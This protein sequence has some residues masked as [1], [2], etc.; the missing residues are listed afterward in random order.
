MKHKTAAVRP[1]DI[2]KM[3]GFGFCPLLNHLGISIFSYTLSLLQIYLSLIPVF[4]LAL[5]FISYLT[6]TTV[7]A[8]VGCYR[9]L[10]M[11]T[12]C[13]TFNILRQAWKYFKFFLILSSLIDYWI[14]LKNSN[15]FHRILTFPSAWSLVKSD[16][17]NENLVI[18]LTVLFLLFPPFWII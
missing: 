10:S 15:K 3:A 14:S 17:V 1:K 7:H 12:V 5:A 6:L 9:G 16:S 4:M 8:W 18:L 13:L 2:I 11:A